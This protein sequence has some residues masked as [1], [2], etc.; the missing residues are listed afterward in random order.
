[1]QWICLR[2]NEKHKIEILPIIGSLKST[3][4]PVLLL[5]C[6]LPRQTLREKRERSL[7]PLA[8]I[9]LIGCEW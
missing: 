5:K 8:P 3:R 6:P 2:S 9:G 4:F 1:M 7:F